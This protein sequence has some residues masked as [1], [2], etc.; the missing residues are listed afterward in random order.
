MNRYTYHDGQ[1]VQDGDLIA[2]GPYGTCLV[3]LRP[4]YAVLR[5]TALFGETTE[6]GDPDRVFAES[7][8]LRRHNEDEEDERLAA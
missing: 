2:A 7:D 8:L 6:L 5:N 4:G 3:T 1:P